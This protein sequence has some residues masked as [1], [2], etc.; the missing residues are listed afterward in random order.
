MLSEIRGFGLR[1]LS[2]GA[3]PASQESAVAGLTPETDEERKQRKASEKAA[4]KTEHERRGSL[5][6]RLARVISGVNNGGG[7]KDGVGSSK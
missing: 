5:T 1:S 3:Q 2:V 4:K 7:S 6:E